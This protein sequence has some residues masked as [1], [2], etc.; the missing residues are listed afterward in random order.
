MAF[1]SN[2]PQPSSMF[3]NSMDSNPSNLN[4]ENLQPVLFLEPPFWCSISYYELNLRVGEPFHAS[5]RSFTVDGYTDPSS[6]ERFCLGILSNVNRDPSVEKARRHI[7]MI[8]N[9]DLDILFLFILKFFYFFLGFVLFCFVL[10]LG[11]ISFRSWCAL[12]LH[13]RRSIR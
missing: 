3:D 13:R 6:S 11:I 10:A 8:L 1:A 9:M 5:V 7:G 2:T 12:L 4:I